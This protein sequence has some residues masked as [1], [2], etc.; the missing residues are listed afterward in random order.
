MLRSIINASLRFRLLV[1]AIAAGIIGVGITQLN[2][3][4]VDVLPEFTPPYAEVQTEALGLSAQEVEQLITVPLEADLLNGVQGVDVIRSESVPSLSSI[5][6]VFEPGTDIYRARQLIEERLTQAHAL[7][8]VSAPPTLLQ[9]L[10]SSSR[11]M[12]IGMSSK[13]ISP[14]DKSVIARW[15][16]QPR[17]MGVPGV[18]NVAVWGMRDQ[19]L[20]VQVD[21]ERLRDRDVTL[22]QVISTSGNAQVVSPLSFLEGSTP[23]SGGFIET[24]Q[25]RLQVRNVLEKIADPKELGK[26]PVEGTGGKL[27][28]S[29]VSDIKVDHQPLIGDAVVNDADGLLLVVE[30]FPGANTAEVTEGVEDALEKLSPGLRGMEVDTSVFRPATFIEDAVDNIALTVTIAAVLAA[31]MLAAFLFHWRTV[32]VALVTIP[33]SL[34][35]AAVVL[36]LLGESLNA[37]SFAGLAI[38]LAVV[39]GDAVAGAENVSRRL[40]EHRES[41][42]EGSVASVVVE[43]SHEVRSPLAYGDAHRPAGDRA[44]RRDGGPARGVLRAARAGVRP[45]GRRRDGRRADA[46]ARAQPP[47]GL[48]RAARRRLAAASTACARATT[49]RFG[50]S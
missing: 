34:V 31:L 1:V 45:G 37:I 7:P 20:Q 6:M 33:V 43:A 24:P 30:K 47:A 12:M 3:A 50:A 29:D 4:P 13:D 5:T 36:D 26:V 18:A 2:D 10:S 22:S 46:D 11:V 40:R 9:P 35:A 16:V 8:N 49:A 28:L 19:Q 44:R 25:Q 39:V 23:G 41:G 32:L 14:I 17:L 48:P 27:R 21:P 15:T 42:A 38:G